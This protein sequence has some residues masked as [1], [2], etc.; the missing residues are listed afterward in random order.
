MIKNILCALFRLH[1]RDEY[2]ELERENRKLRYKQ[3]EQT[4]ECAAWSKRVDDALYDQRDYFK[5]LLMERGRRV[6]GNLKQS[7]PRIVTA[8][9][10][11][12]PTANVLLQPGPRGGVIAKVYVVPTKLD[13]QCLHLALYGGELWGGWQEKNII[14]TYKGLNVLYERQCG[15]VEQAKEE[16]NKC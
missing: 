11:I 7:K 5:P 13:L 14:V 15:P 10:T 6:F 8:S 16:H 12:V 9:P 1:P 2:E 4:R 3:W